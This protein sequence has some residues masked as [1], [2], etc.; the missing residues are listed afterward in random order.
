MAVVQF[1]KNSSSRS[2]PPSPTSSRRY[3]PTDGGIGGTTRTTRSDNH[4]TT[5]GNGGRFGEQTL[6]IHDVIHSLEDHI[7]NSVAVRELCC[8]EILNGDTDLESLD[9]FF[10]R[11]CFQMNHLESLRLQKNGL[12]P[13]CSHSLS[14]LIMTEALTELDLSGNRLGDGLMSLV[15]ALTGPSCRLVKL[16]INDNKIGSKGA[17]AIASLLRNNQTIEELSLSNNALGTRTIKS[18]IVD[19]CDNQKL[20]KLDVSYN[21]IG[22]RG[23]N[24]L[25]AALDPEVS[26]CNLADLNLTYNKIGAPGVF[27][28]CKALLEGNKTLHRID[29]SLN[30]IGPEGADCFGAVLKYSHTLEELILSRNNVGAGGVM[31]LLRGLE[32]SEQRTNLHV[33][34]LSWNSLTDDAAIMIADVLRGNGVLRSLNLASNAIGSRGV[35]AL[36]RSLTYDLACECERAC[37]KKQSCLYS[38]M[39]EELLPTVKPHR[40]GVADALVVPLLCCILYCCHLIF[41]FLSRSAGIGS[42]R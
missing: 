8:C 39:R 29:L 14:H 9:N 41:C 19:L 36:A 16:N 35:I 10:S 5:I 31:N 21:K 15:N 38:D 42:G 30:R 34:D 2:P 17:P 40:A 25:A 13:A 1:Y 24:L 4:E 23:A 33:L 37:F 12:T 6:T 27:S 11:N 20:L 3:F 18:I 28:V 22:D 32:A 7:T 26:R